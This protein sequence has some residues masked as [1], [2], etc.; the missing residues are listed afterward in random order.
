MGQRDARFISKDLSLRVSR[1]GL[2]QHWKTSVGGQLH[3]HKGSQALDEMSQP[4]L[5]QSTGGG[6]GFLYLPCVPSVT[7]PRSRR[8]HPVHQG[9]GLGASWL[10]PGPPPWGRCPAHCTKNKT[11]LA[12]AFLTSPRLCCG[13]NSTK[14]AQG[15][16]RQHPT[17]AFTTCLASLQ[18]PP[19]FLLRE[20]RLMCSSVP[21][22]C[23]QVLPGVKSQFYHLSNVSLPQ[24]STL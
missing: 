23:P 17:V 7:S 10:Q 6:T 21:R 12:S 9:V 22:L 14:P 5:L 4:S 15:E 3:L 13:Q 18:V 1:T 2:D 24:F 20:G 8:R 16:H 19:R 11:Q